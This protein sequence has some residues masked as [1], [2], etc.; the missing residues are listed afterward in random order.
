M[1]SEQGAVLLCYHCGN[2]T[3]MDLIKH[4]KH[5]DSEE[6]A[7]SYGYIHNSADFVRNWYMYSCKVCG[8]IT[9]QR[10][11]WFSEETHP[12]GRPIINSQVVYPQVTNKNSDMPDGVFEAFQ[13]A[14]KVRH[15]DGAICALSVRRA[16]EKMCKDKGATQNDLYRKLKHLA[17]TKVLPPIVDEMA[18]ILKQ[19]GNAAAHADDI[20]FDDGIV[21]SI[22]EFTQ[23]ILDYVYNL[24]AKLKRVQDLRSGLGTDNTN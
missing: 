10:E 8:E 11:N 5:V 17:D 18:Y 23:I 4:H 14:I 7:D 3:F 24:P 15:I 1:S 2:R 9:V 20:V 21:T 12:D 16:L 19:L 6:I 22:I 13:A